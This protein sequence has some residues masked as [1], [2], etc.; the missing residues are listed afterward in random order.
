[1][2]LKVKPIVIPGFKKT[3]TTLGYLLLFFP[4]IV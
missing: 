3:K 4:H 1:M 2:V